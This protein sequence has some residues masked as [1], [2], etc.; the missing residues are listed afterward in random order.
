MDLKKIRSICFTACIVSI[1]IG[2]L[3]GLALIWGIVKDSEFAWKVFMTLGL[4]FV[5]ASLTLSVA[6]YL[7]SREEK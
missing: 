6:R 7:G 4:F 3:L 2:L 1:I 5:S